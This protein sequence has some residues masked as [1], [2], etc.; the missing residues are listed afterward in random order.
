MIS[1]EGYYDSEE[2]DLEHYVQAVSQ[3]VDKCPK[4]KIT[5]ALESCGSNVEKAVKKIKEQS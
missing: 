4:K 3:R 2:E 1:E 5:E